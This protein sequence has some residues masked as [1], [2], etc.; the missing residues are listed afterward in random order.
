ALEA[1]YTQGEAWLNALLD[2]LNGNLNYLT[3]FVSHQLPS[4]RLYRHE[5]TY[6]VWVDFSALGLEHKDLQHKLVHE[7]GLGLSE[8]SIFGPGGE[9]HMR[10][11]IACP[12]SVLETAMKALQACCV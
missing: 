12:R 2:Y 6:L 11:N 7:A 9:Q 3:D 1:A 8:G 5:A 10:I 4:L